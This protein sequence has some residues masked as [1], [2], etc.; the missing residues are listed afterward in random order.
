M[1]KTGERFNCIYLNDGGQ[2]A[3]II[4][5]ALIAFINEA[6][7]TLDAA[8]YDAHF[9]DNAV[10]LTIVDA[11]DAAEARGVHVRAVYNHMPSD[12]TTVVGGDPQSGP[13]ILQKLAAAVPSQAIPGEPDLMHHKYMV[14]DGSAVWTG[15][16]N[17]T[18]D[19]WTRMEN[20]VITVQSTDLATAYTQDF[21][22]LWTK[23]HVDRTGTFDDQAETITYRGTPMSIRAMFSP[24]RGR[25]ISS[26][27]AKHIAA[28]DTRIRIASPVLTSAN[29]LSAL[30]ERVN[31]PGIDAKLVVDGPQMAQ[32]C[33]QWGG[34]PRAAWKVPMFRHVESSGFLVS[35]PSTPWQPGDGLHD[36]M[37]AKVV[38]CDDTV[39]T[40]SYNCSRSGERNAE[41]VLEIVSRSFADEC[42]AFI[43]Q[44]HNRYG[45][46]APKH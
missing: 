9:R 46:A 32:A 15:S 31:E 1:S 22:Q 28:A 20:M 16:T 19:A 23:K 6:K 11:L 14:R 39:I 30:S 42:A 17:W 35:K 29:I 3:A 25:A 12:P 24:G 37:H 8:I 2:P 43:D 45:A 40:G 34:D 44:V 7:V 4:H 27:I 10:G 41:N 26:T 38:V 33:R 5:E 13:S 36:F 21:E 18:T